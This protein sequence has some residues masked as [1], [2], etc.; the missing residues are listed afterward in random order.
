MQIEENFRDTKSLAFGM[1]TEIGR[2]RSALRLQALLLIATL[3]ACE[4]M[5]TMRPCLRGSMRR[6]AACEQRNGPRAFAVMMRSH[7]SAVSSRAARSA[8]ATR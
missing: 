1:G 3:A 5:F 6:A 2:S 8:A 4:L 7:C